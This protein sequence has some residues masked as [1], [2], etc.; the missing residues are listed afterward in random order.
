[1][2]KFRC[3]YNSP[4]QEKKKGKKKLMGNSHEN[5]FLKKK[6]FLKP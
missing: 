2:L 6:I 5:L 4:S 1:M 3:N